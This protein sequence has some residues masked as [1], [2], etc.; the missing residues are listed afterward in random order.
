VANKLLR[1]TGYGWSYPHGY[2]EL[3]DE[4]K[5]QAKRALAQYETISSKLLPKN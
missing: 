2:G 1:G 5:L 3:T 4:E